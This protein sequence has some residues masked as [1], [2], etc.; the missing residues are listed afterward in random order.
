V[1]INYGA[2]RNQIGGTQPGERNVLSGNRRSGVELSYG[3]TNAGNHIAGNYIGLHPDGSAHDYT[4]NVEPG[5]VLK[6][7]VNNN[8]VE[9]N[10]IA[11][12]LGG[13]VWLD[14]FGNSDAAHNNIVRNNRIG[15]GADGTPMG[16]GEFGVRLTTALSQIGPGNIIAYNPAGV[17]VEGVDNDGNI[18]TQNS[19]FNNSGLGIDLAPMGQVNGNDPNDA[20]AGPNQQLNHPV[21]IDATT[22]VVTGTACANCR[23]EVFIA[24]AKAVVHGEGQ[25]FAGAVTAGASGAFT[26][27]LQNASPGDY[28]TATATDSMS[29]TSEFSL[30]FP[31]IP[32]V[33]VAPTELAVVEVGPPVSYTLALN[34]APSSDVTIT[35]SGDSQV[36]VSHNVVVFTPANWNTP[37]A[38]MVTAVQDGIDEQPH[39]ATIH[40]TAQSAD[41]RFDNI[42]VQ[43]VVVNITDRAA[44]QPIA[45]PLIRRDG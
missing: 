25:V 3:A 1:D 30:N 29:N 5:V 41:G 40:H 17:R 6:D 28:L 16:N 9:H 38:I 45:L 22:G 14:R 4:A 11:N 15:L 8:L 39:Q 12:N 35:I 2:A 37:Q 18:I 34:R 13:G 21:L 7:Q 42:A 43:D 23:V 20:D 36:T 26:A 19:I 44:A 24:D 10:V 27:T 32:G 33:I 31:T